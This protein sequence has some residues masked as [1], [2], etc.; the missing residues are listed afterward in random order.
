MTDR[1]RGPKRKLQA[2]YRALSQHRRAM[3]RDSYF[4]LLD[5]PGH[6][7]ARHIFIIGIARFLCALRVFDVQA[8]SSP[9]RLPLWQI[10]FYVMASIAE[11][12]CGEKLHTQLINQSIIHSL[13]QLIWCPGKWSFHFKTTIFIIQLTQANVKTTYKC[14]NL[15]TSELPSSLQACL[16]C[17][18]HVCHCPSIYIPWLQDSAETLQC[19]CG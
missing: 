8:S 1:H 10:L 9:P 16:R 2:G 12:A 5:I 17:W 11:L 13:T 7:N 3:C 18:H 6:C 14:F 15:T 4:C 19:Q